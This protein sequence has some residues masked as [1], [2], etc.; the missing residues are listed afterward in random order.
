M[1]VAR[2]TR[3]VVYASAFGVPADKAQDDF[4]DPESRIMKTANGFEQ[5]YNAQAAADEASR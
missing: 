3:K 1:P 4:T 2:A 5:C